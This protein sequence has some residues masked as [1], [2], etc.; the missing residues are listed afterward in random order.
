MNDYYDGLL[1]IYFD[2][3][4]LKTAIKEVFKRQRTGLISQEI[5]AAL[6]SLILL[7]SHLQTQYQLQKCESY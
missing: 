3:V 2:G 6:S 7:I 1:L 4:Q 5:S